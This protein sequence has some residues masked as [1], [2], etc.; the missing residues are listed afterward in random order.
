MKPNYKVNNSAC[1]RFRFARILGPFRQC[2]RRY[3]HLVHRHTHAA[4]IALVALAANLL[5]GQTKAQTFTTIKS[6]GILTNVTGFA[7]QSQLVQGPDGTLYGTTQEGGSLGNGTV[8][9]LELS[10]P[11]TR[12]PLTAQAVGGAVILTWNNPAFALQA[13]SEVI[14]TYTNIPG[15]KSPYTNAILDLEGSSG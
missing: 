4:G 10:D 12:I 2:P 13:N 7:P 9:K 8:F 5:T 15:A 14:G 11:L 3:R 1:A 6:F